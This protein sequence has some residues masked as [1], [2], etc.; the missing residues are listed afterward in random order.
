[1]SSSSCSYNTIGFEGSLPVEVPGVEEIGLS[2]TCGCG[3]CGAILGTGN[4]GNVGGRE[5]VPGEQF[6]DKMGTRRCTSP[7][8]R[9]GDSSHDAGDKTWHVLSGCSGESAANKSY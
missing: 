4:F 9:K 6:P 5:P 2:S 7:S 8:N 3:D 1:M